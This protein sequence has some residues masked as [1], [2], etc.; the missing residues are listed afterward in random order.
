MLCLC[1]SLERTSRFA[2]LSCTTCHPYHQNDKREEMASFQGSAG[3]ASRARALAAQRVEDRD[4]FE[5]QLAVLG[6]Q[7]AAVSAANIPLAERFRRGSVLQRDQREGEK[8]EEEKGLET[9]E[10]APS[11]D[12]GSSGIGGLVTLEEFRK[13]KFAA[14]GKETTDSGAAGSDPDDKKR[15]RKGEKGHD[16]EDGHDDDDEEE[17][18]KTRLARE[19]RLALVASMREKRDKREERR[20]AV[21]RTAKLSFGG[22]EDDEED[23]DDE[24]EGNA[25]RLGLGGTR[26]GLGGGG[27]LRGVLKNPDVETAFLPDRERDAREAKERARLEAIWKAEQTK[28]KQEMITIPCSYYDGMDHQSV[29]HVRR[30]N[31]I[32]QVLMLV[33]QDSYRELRDV[34]VDGVVFVW[35][36]LILPNELSFYDL[37]LTGAKRTKISSPR[38][39]VLEGELLF[40]F[41]NI[42]RLQQATVVQ[43]SWYERNKF[44]A[45]ACF[46]ERFD[47]QKGGEHYSLGDA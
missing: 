19:A 25:P 1:Y 2:N 39:K 23:D 8:G 26:L 3:D 31:T 13:R 46:W 6:E 10:K 37:M 16:G 30:G 47:P 44:S 40:D 29:Q 38:A 7:S 45:P 14:L 17:D 20:R 33:V 18:E 41:D 5:Q 24:G 42:R 22:E 21:G 34:G 36:D 9:D 28:R 32:A 43:K 11:H 35:E 4:R 27:G 15:A 12:S